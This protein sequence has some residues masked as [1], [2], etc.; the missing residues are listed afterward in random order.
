MCVTTT[1]QVHSSATERFRS[2]HKCLCPTFDKKYDLRF[3]CHFETL[4]DLLLILCSL[5]RNIRDVTAKQ[6]DGAVPIFDLLH[7]EKY[8]PHKHL[9]ILFRALLGTFTKPTSKNVFFRKRKAIS[10]WYQ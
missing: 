4:Q 7:D 10:T 2:I 1:S 8:I 6:M 5:R 3:I 9:S